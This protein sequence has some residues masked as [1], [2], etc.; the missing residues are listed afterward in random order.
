MRHMK[1]AGTA[2]LALA[3]ALT[4][5]LSGCGPQEEGGSPSAATPTPTPAADSGDYEFIFTG[6]SS[7]FAGGRTM[8]VTVYG[9][10]DE[11]NSIELRV[12][13]YPQILIDGYYTYVEGKGYKLYF[14]DASSAFV[15]TQFHP[16]DNTFTFRYT[17]DMGDTL[18]SARVAFTCQ[19]D[20]F[21]AEYDGEGLGRTPPTFV[22]TVAG[23][24]GGAVSLVCRED[25]TFDTAAL[26]NTFGGGRTGTWEYDEEND[27]YLFHFNPDRNYSTNYERNEA[28]AEG[29]YLG[30]NRVT[31]GST[32]GERQ[33][34]YLTGADPICF[35]LPIT[36]EDFD[37]INEPYKS[38]FS[39]DPETGRCDIRVKDLPNLD[40]LVSALSRGNN[41][42]DYRELPDIYYY[43]MED[44]SLNFLPECAT[45][46]D[47]DTGDYTLIWSVSNGKYSLAQ[48][49]YNPEA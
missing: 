26:S 14:N 27:Q 42:D 41:P 49:T 39:Y 5:L 12:A 37:P 48:G 38:G 33:F 34:T 46:Y 25:G 16:E 19:D 7:D 18:G 2:V 11:N 24:G 17:L 30:Y 20:A 36:S 31:D 32:S 47:P 10:K 13:E 1:H 15:Y 28:D 9:L 43:V 45:T 6:A 22:G 21:A 40:E 8:N 4:M 44:G 35:D 23:V 29:H 3:L